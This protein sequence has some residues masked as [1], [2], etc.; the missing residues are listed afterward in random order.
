[1]IFPTLDIKGVL[2][3]G[4]NVCSVL[5]AWQRGFEYG[6]Y[7]GMVM[8]NVTRHNELIW[9]VSKYQNS[10]DRIGP[11]GTPISCLLIRSSAKVT[12]VQLFRAFRIFIFLDV[13]QSSGDPYLKQNIV[14]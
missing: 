5:G 7:R 9:Q 4:V 10:V 6:L 8:Y 13:L 3:K 14:K 12:F 1:M 2:S 11:W